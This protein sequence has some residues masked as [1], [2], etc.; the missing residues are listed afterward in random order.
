MAVSL[1]KAGR[2]KPKVR[3]GQAISEFQADLSSIEMAQFQS[4]QQNASKSPPDIRDIMQI[5]AESSQ[6]TGPQGRCFGPR[7]TNILQAVQKFAALGYIVVG[8][9]QNMLACGVW[10][11]V[12]LTLLTVVKRSAY[13]ERLSSMLMAGGRSAPRNQI[14]GAI[15]P[16]SVRL[17][18]SMTECFIVIVQLCHYML[19]LSRKTGFGQWLAT[20]VDSKLAVFESDLGRWATSTKEEVRIPMTQQ[21]A[22]EATENS[23]FRSV[24]RRRHETDGHEKQLRAWKRILYTCLGYDHEASW[25]R[26]RKLGNS[27]IY[28]MSNVYSAWKLAE[29]LS[30]LLCIGKLGSGKSVL[31][32]NAVDDLTLNANATATIA[33]FSW[34]HE[35]LESM[36]A[37]P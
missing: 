33:Y 24:M 34:Q 10:S 3:L 27:N 30:T 19:K 18:E 35:A 7:L 17:R 12:R 6:F 26:T 20:L 1:A 15:Y 4:H 31:L 23:R 32:A 14:M 13:F 8:G 11:L 28:K 22:H 36:N 29:A 37:Q 16:Q 21:V 2:L 9:S 5:T 25:K